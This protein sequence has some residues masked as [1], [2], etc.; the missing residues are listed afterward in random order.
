MCNHSSSTMQ[1]CTNLPISTIF[2]PILIL[3]IVVFLT[4]IFHLYVIA[5]IVPM[6]MS[7]VEIN[8]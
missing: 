6:W 4:V 5:T 2:I 3:T 8:K 1:S 7:Y